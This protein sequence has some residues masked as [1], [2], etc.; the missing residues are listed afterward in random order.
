MCIDHPEV[1]ALIGRVQDRR[2]IT[3]G[4]S[5]QADVRLIDVSSREAKAA[6][7]CGIANRRTGRRRT[8]DGPRASACPATTIC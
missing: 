4:Q 8:I 7:P 2:I 3:Y 1:Q 6:F 5:P